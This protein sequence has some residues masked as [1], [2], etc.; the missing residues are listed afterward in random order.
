MMLRRGEIVP[1]I[2]KPAQPGMGNRHHRREDL[3][4]APGLGQR[5]LMDLV[6][7]TQV[8]LHELDAGELSDRQVKEGA[9]MLFAREREALPKRIRGE[10]N[11]PRLLRQQ[12]QVEGDDRSEEHTSELQ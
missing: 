10:G 1:F 12:P 4:K 2:M 6:G 8:T 9:V 7:R 3:A 11:I 5:L